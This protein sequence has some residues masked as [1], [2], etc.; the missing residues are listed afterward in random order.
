MG[1]AAD[2]RPCAGGHTPCLTLTAAGETGFD[3]KRLKAPWTFT[4]HCFGNVPFRNGLIWHHLCTP[5][6]IQTRW[7]G[8]LSLKFCKYCFVGQ[9]KNFFLVSL[10]PQGYQI[11]MLYVLIKGYTDKP[12][13]RWLKIP[14]QMHISNIYTFFTC[15]RGYSMIVLCLM[16]IVLYIKWHGLPLGMG[17]NSSLWVLDY[18]K[19]K[20]CSFSRILIIHSAEACVQR[21][22]GRRKVCI[23]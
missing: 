8:W 12:F 16:C 19:K 17:I 11:T 10:N 6:E 4:L 22:V 15:L 20:I 14:I 9:W 7:A 1:L 21:V 23:S 5:Y 2:P 3:G 18:K 13:S